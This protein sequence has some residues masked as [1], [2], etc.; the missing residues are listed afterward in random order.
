MSRYTL[1]YACPGCGLAS[2]ENHV[3]PQDDG[4]D[5]EDLA[6]G[7]PMAWRELMALSNTEPYY[8]LTPGELSRIVEFSLNAFLNHLR[9]GC[10]QLDAANLA[11][12]EVKQY[13]DEAQY[14]KPRQE[15]EK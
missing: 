1:H 6:A 8:K 4:L 15:S 13:V 9:R 10:G 14:R 11:I 3:C 12:M 2:T 7:H 5:L